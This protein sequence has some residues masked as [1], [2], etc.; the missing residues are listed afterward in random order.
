MKNYGDRYL[1]VQEAN[2]K[3]L[4]QEPGIRLKNK[5]KPRRLVENFKILDI[6]GSMITVESQSSGKTLTRI[7]RVLFN[8]ILNKQNNQSV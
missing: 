6:N 7:L 4:Y 5:R 3:V 1:H 2:F 8:Q